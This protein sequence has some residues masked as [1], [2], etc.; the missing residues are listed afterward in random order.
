MH[1]MKLPWQLDGAHMDTWNAPRNL[2]ELKF[3]PVCSVKIYLPPWTTK[4][5]SENV[6]LT[7]LKVVTLNFYLR[8]CWKGGL[9]TKNEHVLKSWQCHYHV[10]GAETS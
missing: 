6:F 2:Q 10:G 5:G 9:L 7:C 8:G 3:Y 4:N 1:S